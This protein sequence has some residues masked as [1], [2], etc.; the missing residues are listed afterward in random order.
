MAEYATPH[1][2]EIR[3]AHDSSLQKYVGLRK[4]LTRS[5]LIR[6]RG[7]L[8]MQ[9]YVF[10]RLH[11]NLRPK[12]TLMIHSISVSTNKSQ[13][14]MIR[15]NH[16]NFFIQDVLHISGNGESSLSL[17]PTTISYI[18]K[19]DYKPPSFCYMPPEIL[20]YYPWFKERIDVIGGKHSFSCSN[21]ESCFIQVW[22]ENRVNRDIMTVYSFSM[23]LTW[24]WSG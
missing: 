20:Q 17:G 21:G 13:C 12:I 22:E 19:G 7:L 9:G 11:M 1:S 5:S 8:G 10:I 6:C 14:L 18:Y 24:M 3:T 23:H 2:R 15:C 16:Q 4:M